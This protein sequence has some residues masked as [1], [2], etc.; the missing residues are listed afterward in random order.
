MAPVDSPM[1]FAIP[2]SEHCN[3]CQTTYATSYGQ[4][5]TGYTSPTAPQGYGTGAYDTTTLCL[6]PPRPPMQLS[7][8]MAL[9]LLAKLMGS[10][11]Q[12]PHL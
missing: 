9:S 6:L 12:P 4:A 5:P 10:S 7:L 8:H 1:M 3:L 2:R 11:Q